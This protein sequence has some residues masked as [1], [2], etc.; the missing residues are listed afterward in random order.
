MTTPFH[1]KTWR[2]M[3]LVD[4]DAKAYYT[5]GRRVEHEKCQVELNELLAYIDRL[6]TQLEESHLARIEAQNPGIDMDEVR[7]S[8]ADPSR[9]VKP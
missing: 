2:T 4:T 5:I 6:K 7:A 3:I 1:E 8:R 9:V